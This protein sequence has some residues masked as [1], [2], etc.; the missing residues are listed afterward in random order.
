MATLIRMR[1][2]TRV[3]GSTAPCSARYVAQMSV[4]YEDLRIETRALAQ[5]SIPALD[6]TDKRYRQHYFLRRSI[7]TLV[8]FAE[9]LRL[10]NACP[11]FGN[12]RG[13][14]TGELTDRW[15][16]GIQ[17]FQKT[18]SYLRPI[19]NDTGGH[20]G[21]KAAEYA[22]THFSADAVGKI[23]VDEEGRT[24][25]LHF[26]GEIAATAILKHLKDQNTEVGFSPLLKTALEG[27]HHATTCVHCL[28]VT[29]LWQR[30]G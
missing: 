27:Y 17:F 24:I 8:E 1:E 15:N 11:D 9:A 20:F 3:F 29:Y 14:F 19:R 28:A 18:E 21:P 25:H 5:D 23:Q 6:V 10:L 7:A 13:A 2:L 26:A 30:F 22:V 4:L 12:A 16:A